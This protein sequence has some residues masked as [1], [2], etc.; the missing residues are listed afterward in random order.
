MM[1]MAQET[2]M[3]QWTEAVEEISHSLIS[4]LHKCFRVNIRFERNIVAVKADWQ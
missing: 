1:D 2:E 4:D 3:M